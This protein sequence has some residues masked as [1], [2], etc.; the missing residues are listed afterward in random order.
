[1]QQTRTSKWYTAYCKFLKNSA[2]KGES[3]SEICKLEQ[4][5]VLPLAVSVHFG[6]LPEMGVCQRVFR[7]LLKDR[8]GVRS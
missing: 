8:L 2:S 3:R 4:T 6:Q 1:M 5:C 7:S